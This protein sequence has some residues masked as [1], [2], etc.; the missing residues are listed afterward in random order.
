[1]IFFNYGLNVK[2]QFIRRLKKTESFHKNVFKITI[3]WRLIKLT[4]EVNLHV[5]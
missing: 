5:V 1:M 4:F 3:M 2:W